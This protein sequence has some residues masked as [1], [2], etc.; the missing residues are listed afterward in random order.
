MTATGTP[1]EDRRRGLFA[2]IG[3]GILVAATGVGA[4]DLAGSALAGNR[5]GTAVLWAVLVGAFIKFV[6]NEG[7]AR[8]QLA[9]GHT[10]LFATLSRLPAIRVPFLLYFLLWAFLVG[11]ALMSACGV[12][13]HALLPLFADPT[14]DKILYGI[15]HSL[16]GLLLVRIGGFALFEKVMSI[17][18]ALM[19]VTVLATAAY[20]WP[21][22]GVVLHGLFVPTIPAAGGEGVQWTVALM[23]GIGGTLTILCYGYWIREEGRVD[24]SHL[25]ACRFDLAL[26]YAM[27]AMFGIGMVIIGST[28]QVEGGGA[29]LVV[30][31]ADRLGDQLGPLGRYAFLL[32]AWAAIASSLLGVW[33]SAPYLFADIVRHFRKDEVS[34]VAHGGSLEQT[35]AYRGFLVAIAVVP[36][37]GLLIGFARMQ[38]I[39]AITGAMFMPMV[40]AVLLYLN[41]QALVGA[42]FR[43]RPLTV[44]VLIGTLLLF[45]ITGY[46]EISGRG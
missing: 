43:N 18:I 15:L 32:G 21:G 22:L 17:A 10:P 44:C 1:G 8:F 26:A 46:L 6:Q 9:T 37:I 4:G 19:F 30:R 3:P 35:R 31:L 39:T 11:A 38:K 42:R 16:V 34:A 20:L 2:R 28:I 36:M 5:L 14:H 27:T 45:L 13:G 23:G 7:L 29:T 33:Q 24:G 41:R 12:A 40:A 25:R